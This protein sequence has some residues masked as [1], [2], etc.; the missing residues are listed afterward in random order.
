M[1]RSENELGLAANP[2]RLYLYERNCRNRDRP[3]VSEPAS[4]CQHLIIPASRFCLCIIGNDR[5]TSAT[6]HIR[7]LQDLD[8][9]HISSARLACC[10][11]LSCTL[12]SPETRDL[13]SPSH[14]R[15]F[16]ANEHRATMA[17]D[18]SDHEKPG[19]DDERV[20]RSDG[21]VSSGDETRVG[22]S[23]AHEHERG[24][25]AVGR[26]EDGEENGDAG[27]D[28][29]EK[30]QRP[31]GN[32]APA[33]PDKLPPHMQP[34]PDGGLKAWMQ[35][36]GAF[37]L[38]FNTWGLINTFGVYQTYYEAG[39]I[40]EASSSDIGWIGAVQAAALLLTG[41]IAGPLYDRG[42]FRH[43]LVVGTFLIVFGHMMLSLSHALWHAVL[44]QGLCLGIGAGCLFLPAVAVLP[45]YFRKKLG[46]AVG[47]AASG[48]SLGGIIYPIMFYK[49]IAEV[50]FGWGVRI[51]GFTALALL[52][53]PVAFMQMRFKPPKPRA[54]FD[55]TA[56][57]DGP[58]LL[59][60]LA[61]ITGFVGFYGGLFYI[62]YFGQATG[63]TD[64]SLSFYLI[65]ILNAGSCFGRTVPNYLSDK[66]GAINMLIPGLLLLCILAVTNVAGL[67]VIALLFGFFSGVFIAL[68]AVVVVNLTKDKSRIGTR[69]GMAF[70]FV[71][72]G[73][74]IGGPG[75]GA[76]IGS[77]PTDLHWRNTW[78]FCGVW[79]LA[80]GLLFTWLR[81]WVAGG[82]LRAKV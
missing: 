74:L 31:N 8:I 29:Q 46:T 35:V 7:T 26:A 50:G 79:I 56:F 67:V 72:V 34:P 48:S 17:P 13:L 43:L 12:R 30:E 1:P 16:R 77:D 32:A 63:I 78:I 44:S 23:A 58:F 27:N 25:E 75:T 21:Q 69:I 47:L 65:P 2:I 70:A 55:P 73:A 64:A 80:S 49:I 37:M 18:A 10:D 45:T 59:L 28:T 41:L 9:N 57:R 52:A 5:E 11:C 38:F 4:L 76:V 54:V 22:E 14:L 33:A 36:L 71:V 60:C 82:K 40:F 6:A 66:T 61:L 62:S 3:S 39:T 20:D 53:I 15:A 51:L 81:V 24:V 42:Y 19:L 68:P